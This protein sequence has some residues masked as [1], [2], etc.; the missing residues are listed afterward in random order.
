MQSSAQP[1]DQARGLR[2]LLQQRQRRSPS[3]RSCAHAITIHSSKGGVGKSV[4]AL[5][6][7]VSL[8]HFGQRVCLLDAHPGVGNVD[9]LC[10]LS[11]YWNL[12][13]VIAGARSLTEILQSGPG[14]IDVLPGAAHLAELADC[15]PHVQQ[16]LLQQLQA[17][18]SQYDVLLVDS[19]AHQPQVT[20]AWAAA[21]NTVL[22]VTTG[23]PTAIAEAYAAIKRLHG[24]ADLSLCAVVNRATELQAQRILERLQ[25]TTTNFLHDSLA[26]GFGIPDDPAVA[27]SVFARC[28]VVERTP[29]SPAARAIRQLAERLVHR[30]VLRSRDSFFGRIWPMIARTATETI[31]TKGENRTVA[32][33]EFGSIH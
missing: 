10:R 33:N 30:P 15:P 8:A 17:V 14:G 7:A 26:L 23:E 4:L 21:A 12:S 28:P 13:H 9:L 2:A 29:T 1:V 16:T 22:I 3:T 11:G 24:S 25:V 18:E 32:F 20:Q 5:N 19:G 6:L 31:K 27:D